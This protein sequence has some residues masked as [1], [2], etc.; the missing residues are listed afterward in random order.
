MTRNL[1]WIAAGGLCIGIACL[2]L[3]LLAGGRGPRDPAPAST[4][5]PCDMRADGVVAERRLAW[6]GGDAIEIAV[7]ATVR[8][9]GGSSTDIV[10]RGPGPFVERIALR[11]QAVVL[12]C[13][14]IGPPPSIDIAL[15][16][17]A[18]RRIGLNG[19]GHL[20]LENLDQAELAVNIAGNGSVRAQGRVKELRLS[21][22][23]SGRARLAALTL[24]RLIVKLSGS[25]H[26]EASPTQAADIE[27]A[28]T[29]D[30]RLLVRPKSLTSQIAG[31]GL[32][33]Q[34]PPDA[35]EPR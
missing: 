33:S 13:H 19:S 14:P 30:V 32:V 21:I 6:S 15:P 22:A 18:F 28:G 24:R 11:G 23:G 7:P 3:A 26:V 10:V 27:I 5:Q 2:V 4:G 25:G 1:A 16:G 8:Y 12:A 31:S 35:A 29:G 20:V 9:R 17:E 34:P